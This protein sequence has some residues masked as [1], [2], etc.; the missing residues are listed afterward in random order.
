MDRFFR[1]LRGGVAATL[2]VGAGSC[3]PQVHNLEFDPAF[4]SIQVG[5]VELIDV[6]ASDKSGTVIREVPIMLSVDRS[7]VV[8]L[9]RENGVLL[10]VAAGSATVTATA[11]GVTATARVEV[12]ARAED[13]LN[14]KLLDREAFTDSPEGPRTRSNRDDA[15]GDDDP[16]EWHE[17]AGP[18]AAG[19]LIEDD[20]TFDLDGTEAEF[21]S[22]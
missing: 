16:T 4:L 12:V 19:R 9:D 21:D 1:A 8:S 3:S 17:A 18:G 13:E 10:G 11:Q 15:L 14:A 5:A 2:V 7:R 20:A 6:V 22:H